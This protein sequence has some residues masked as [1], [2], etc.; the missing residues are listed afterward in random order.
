MLRQRVLK[1]S[2][3]DK[4]ISSPSTITKPEGTPNNTD[5][6]LSLDRCNGGRV[7]EINQLLQEHRVGDHLFL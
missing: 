7:K 1:L 5:D 2:P 3:T 6:V 4:K